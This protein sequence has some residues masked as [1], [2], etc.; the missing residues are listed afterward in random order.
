MRILH[1]SPTTSRARA[2]GH[3]CSEK[4]FRFTG[5]I[6][7]PAGL[8]CKWLHEETSLKEPLMRKIDVRFAPAL[9][10]LALWVAGIG[11][12]PVSAQMV[13]RLVDYPVTATCATDPATGLAQERVPG[14]RIAVFSEAG[15]PSSA[16][17]YTVS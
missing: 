12:Q 10:A 16:L 15:C 11:A 4:F 3:S 9:A 6:L 2:I 17:L 8:Y 14:N 7:I 1:Q 5:C 13:P